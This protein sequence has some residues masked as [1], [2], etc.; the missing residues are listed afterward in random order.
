MRLGVQTEQCGLTQNSTNLINDTLILKLFGQ[1]WNFSHLVLVFSHF[2][3]MRARGTGSTD[4]SVWTFSYYSEVG[5]F[6]QMF[7]SIQEAIRRGKDNAPE[8]AGKLNLGCTWLRKE[9]HH[10]D[11]SAHRCVC[12]YIHTSRP[13]LFSH[14]WRWGCWQEEHSIYIWLLQSFCSSC[15]ETYGATVQQ[16]K[17]AHLCT[18][19]NWDWRQPPSW[20]PVHRSSILL[21]H[22]TDV[23]LSWETCL[24]FCSCGLGDSRQ[25][26][27]SIPSCLYVA[28]VCS[29]FCIGSC[30]GFSNI[31]T[32]C[33]W[34]TFKSRKSALLCKYSI[35][36]TAW[37]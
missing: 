5:C 1:W 10:T 7:F 28:L 11:M 35:K 16:I 22:C 23:L 9:F 18:F 26:K 34:L 12:V 36:S 13:K 6:N 2:C 8:V 17:C 4:V 20:M 15:Y 3:T 19:L 21:N 29:L 33:I 31:Q 27:K 32:A 30:P 24:L 37:L 14:C 25:M